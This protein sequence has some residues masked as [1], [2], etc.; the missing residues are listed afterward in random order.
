MKYL[1]VTNHS[2][3]LWQFR[4]E[5]IKELLKRGQVVIATPYVGHEKDFMTLGCRM[6]ETKIERRGMNPLQELSL[7]R[8]Y[9]HIL[10]KEKPDIV[11]TY[12]IKP[13]IYVGS[14]C[15]LMRIPYCA[16]VQG[17]GTAFQNKKMALLSTVLYRHALRRARAVFFEN[18][19]NARYFVTHKI[20]PARRITVLT[21]AGVNLENYSLQPYPSEEDG[22]HFLYLGRIMREKGMDELFSAVRRLKAEYPDKVCFDL[23][24]F[25]E[26]D[27]R[28]TIEEMSG[29]GIVQFHGFQ[30][31]PQPWYM[32]SHCIVLPSWHEGMSNVLLEAAA[33][34]R[35]LITNDIPGCRE[36]VDD[37]EN[38]YL[39]VLK[40][41]DS[42]YNAMK[43]FL[44]LSR[45][46]REDMGRKG[47]GKVEREFDRRLVVKKTL[48]AIHK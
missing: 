42:L 23:V 36:A 24:G 43:T 8:S 9:F 27:Y 18:K 33:T 5:L 41:A 25:F 19:P 26:D 12:S 11:I 22:I 14:L 39:T 38:G 32:A 30:E 47:R 20:L 48:R 45:E 37:G 40:D 4:R 6:I 16:N 3:M 29:K 1:I 15:R 21:G 17:L 28:Q 13:N 7:I 10:R 31:N 2:Y 46:E 34:G 35:A 44:S